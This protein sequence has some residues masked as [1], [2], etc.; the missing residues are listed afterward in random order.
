MLIMQFGTKGEKS[1]NVKL[2]NVYYTVQTLKN[3]SYRISLFLGAFSPTPC[4]RDEKTEA[5]EV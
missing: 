4:G 5:R 3:Q 2:R 1:L